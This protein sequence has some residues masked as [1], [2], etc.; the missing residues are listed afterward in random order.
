MFSSTIFNHLGIQISP[1]TLL[2]LGAGIAW[3]MAY[4][5][6]QLSASMMLIIEAVSAGL[7]LLLGLIIWQHQGFALDWQQLTLQDSNFSGIAMGLVFVVFGF[8]GFQSATS[9]GDEA[10][11]P[12]KTIPKAVLSSVLMTGLFFIL[13]AY[14]E[15][16]GFNSSDVSLA[17]HQE[18]LTFLAKTTQV[19]ILGDAIALAVLFSFLA[20][21]LGSINPAARIFFTM[22]RHGLFHNS[23][24]MAHLSNKTPH[25]ALGL[26]A[27]LVFL[28]PAILWML[29]LPLFQSMGYLGTFCTYGFLL[30]DIL[31]SLAAPC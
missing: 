3:Y 13:M 21:V 12:L 9:L 30:N 22:A 19:S 26:S 4:K 10:K 7:I 25:L 29:G 27:L 31:I 16:L 14:I 8:S 1:I 17:N 5:D 24:G 2:A 23:L 18:P 11:Q 15:V 6:I 28:V 20:C